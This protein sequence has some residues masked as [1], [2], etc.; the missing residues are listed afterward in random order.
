MGWLISR[1]PQLETRN[2]QAWLFGDAWIW[3]CAQPSDFG[4]QTSDYFQ[5]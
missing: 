1:N 4:P 3:L 2:I 5:F